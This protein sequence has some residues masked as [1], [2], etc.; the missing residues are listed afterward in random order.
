MNGLGRSPQPMGEFLVRVTGG[1][2][3]VTVVDSHPLSAARL[4]RM[5]ERDRGVTGP[6]ILTEQEWQALRAICADVKKDTGK[7]SERFIDRKN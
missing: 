1:G 5:K 2:R 3:L 4:D 6:P 7:G